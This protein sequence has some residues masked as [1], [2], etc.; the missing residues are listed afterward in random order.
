MAEIAAGVFSFNVSLEFLR[1]R[2]I[3]ATYMALRAATVWIGRTAVR[4]MNV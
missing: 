4:P 2:K 1:L 3:F